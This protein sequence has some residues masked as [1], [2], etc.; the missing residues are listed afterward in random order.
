MGLEGW[1]GSAPAAVEGGAAAPAAG[2]TSLDA[3]ALDCEAAPDA[4]AEAAEVNIY[5]ADATNGAADASADAE[6]LAAYGQWAASLRGQGATAADL[7]EELTAQCGS[8]E[9]SEDPAC[10]LIRRV[11]RYEGGERAVRALRVAEE[12]APQ[13]VDVSRLDLDCSD[14]GED[15]QAECERSRAVNRYEKLVRE[16]VRG[17]GRC[18]EGGRGGRE[19]FDCSGGVPVVVGRGTCTAVH[20]A[21]GAPAPHYAVAAVCAVPHVHVPRIPRLWRPG[22]CPLVSTALGLCLP[23]FDP[24]TVVAGPPHLTCLAVSPP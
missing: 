11:N 23:C 1:P 6:A 21:S 20:A 17:E 19:A 15:M 7:L 22:M 3:L 2:D 4:C 5:E 12:A 9:G 16:Q 13:Y 10:D 18:M 8:G 24:S 14:A